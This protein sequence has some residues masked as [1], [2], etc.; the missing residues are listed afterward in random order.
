MDPAT[1]HL[2]NRWQSLRTEAGLKRAASVARWLWLAGL[3][4][5]L[6][7]AFGLYYELPPLAVAAA[8]SAMGWVV[9]ERNALKSRISQW[10][11][12]VSY[13]DWGRV[14]NDLGGDQE[15]A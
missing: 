8:A 11:M 14:T 10:P 3:I 12:V 9:A 13:I 5:A 2:L 7:V 15:T 1:K 6:V 4:L